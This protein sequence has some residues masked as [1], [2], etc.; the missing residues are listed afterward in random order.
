MHTDRNSSWGIYWM[1]V[2]NLLVA[3]KHLHHGAGSMGVATW[4]GV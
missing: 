1:Q 4:D 2:I 3:G